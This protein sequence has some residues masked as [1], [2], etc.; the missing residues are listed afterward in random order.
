MPGHGLFATGA[1][2]P[3]GLAGTLRQ[4][5]STLNNLWVGSDLVL[6]GTSVT[7]WPAL[8]GT[9]LGSYVVKP[10]LSRYR[11]Y[12]GVTFPANTGST[13]YLY[14]TLAG[15][16]RTVVAAIVPPALP[17]TNY[18]T[19][20]YNVGSG[21]LCGDAGTSTIYAQGNASA[22][23]VD[24]ASTRNLTAGFRVVGITKG[25]ATNATCVV[26]SDGAAA[27][28]WTGTILAVATFS[29]ALSQTNL[30]LATRAMRNWFRE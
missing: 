2:S 22:F 10:T 23:S 26:G 15:L 21:L 25:A 12:N 3:L 6:S 27:R 24:G 29:G 11:C 17:F 13:S 7:S 30:N 19:V 18:L 9:T 28:A 8:V 4:V 16:P 5:S 1:R 20:E 14:A